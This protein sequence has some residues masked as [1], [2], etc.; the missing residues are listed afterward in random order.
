MAERR[1]LTVTIATD[2]RENLINYQK[3]RKIGLRDDAVEEV[4]L[5]M[6]IWRARIK[7]LEAEVAGL[8]EELRKK[9]IAEE[10]NTIPA[11]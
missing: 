9:Q 10:A 1:R 11:H 5:N 6:P 4:F 3:E 2:A 8:K 7:E